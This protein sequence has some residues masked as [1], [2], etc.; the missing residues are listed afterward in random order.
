MGVIR[1]NG[2]RTVCASV[3]EWAARAS[4]IYLRAHGGGRQGSCPCCLVEGGSTELGRA[5]TSRA[6]LDHNFRSPD[7]RAARAYLGRV[8]F[9]LVS[10]L[11][12]R[13]VHLLH[14]VAELHAEATQG[15]ALALPRVVFGSSP[16]HAPK[17][18]DTRP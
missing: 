11:E 4:S 2:A 16:A 1:N 8:V 17:Y 13:S 6:R 18:L 9:E 3:R 7:A 5:S 14:R 15:V 10:R 12:D